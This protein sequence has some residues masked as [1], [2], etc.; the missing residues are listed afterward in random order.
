MTD[1][2]GQVHTLVADDQKV[3]FGRKQG[4][5][6]PGRVPVAVLAPPPPWEPYGGRRPVVAVVDTGVA[7]HQWLTGTPGDP[8]VLDAGE[9][10]W[11]PPAGR[12]SDGPFR[13]HATFLAGVIRQ[14][15][16]GARILSVQVMGDDGL[17]THE[18]SLAA[19]N[20]LG[21]QDVDVICLAYGYEGEPGQTAKLRDVLWNLAGHGVL[22]V[23]SAGNDGISDPPVYPAAF[24]ADPDPAAV[25]VTSV[26]ATN[27]G[28]DY[29]HYSNYGAWV[30]H[31]AVGSGVISTI[32][33]FNGDLPAPQ[34]PGFLHG[35]AMDPDDFTA[36]F[37]RWSGTS[38]AAARI[39]GLLAQALGADPDPGGPGAAVARATAALAAITSS[40]VST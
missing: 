4:H 37:A 19:L 25:P 2:T 39:A 31:Q 20:W 5:G 24:A 13:G 17:V 35:S 33:E 6:D 18:D 26:G 32:A 40:R 11:V 36:G 30:T 27:P 16:P 7:P 34:V 12:V 1:G 22:V 8:V 21:G 38:F 29:A 23:A 15:A 14:S 28:G 9:Y 10:G 3:A